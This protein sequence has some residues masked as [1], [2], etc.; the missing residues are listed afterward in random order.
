MPARDTI[1]CIKQA[2]E[3]G[4]AR[5]GIKLASLLMFMPDV[6]ALG[7]EPTQGLICTETFY[8]DLNDRTRAFTSRVRRPTAAQRA[9]RA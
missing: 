2:R 5:R 8:W 6:H 4:L 1:N 3:F 7:L 9:A